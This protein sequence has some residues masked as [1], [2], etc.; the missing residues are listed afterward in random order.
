VR[1]DFKSNKLEHQSLRAR[2]LAIAVIGAASMS[3]MA[4]EEKTAYDGN[5]AH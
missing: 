5:T 1:V 4:A 3:V 2:R